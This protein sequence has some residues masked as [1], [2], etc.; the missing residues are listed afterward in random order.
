MAD[1]RIRSRYVMAG[2]VRTHYTETGGNGPALVLLHGGGAG[3]SGEAGFM[4]VLGPL[5]QDFRCIAIDSIGGWGDT[6]VTVPAKYGVESRARHLADFMDALCLDKGH[7]LGNSQGAW[8]VARYTLQHPDRVDKLVMVASATMGGAMQVEVP[9]TPGMKVLM[10]YDGTRE[11]MQAT[12]EAIVWKKDVITK[13]LIDTRHAAAERPGAAEARQA[14]QEGNR[15]FT[16]DPGLSLG[17]DMRDT[18]PKLPHPAIFIWG[19]EDE[20]ASPTIGQQLEPLLPKVKFHWVPEAGHQV[21]T[22]QPETF[23]KIVRDFLKG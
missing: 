11:S 20:F 15:Y 19:N 9:Q 5:G 8:T 4:T 12:M 7:L 14:F 23:V 21:Q 18:L 13:E 1:T 3:S 22:D 2:G 10:S 6:D 17:Y 16:T